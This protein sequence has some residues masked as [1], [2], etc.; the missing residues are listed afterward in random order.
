LHA[1]HQ[2]FKSPS[3]LPFAT[4]SLHLTINIIAPLQSNLSCKIN[5]G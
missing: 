3:R 2:G 4:I 5:L 1:G